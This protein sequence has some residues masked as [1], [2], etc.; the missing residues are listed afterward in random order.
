MTTRM[1]NQVLTKKKSQLMNLL[2]SDLV[3]AGS[4]A[5]PLEYQWEDEGPLANQVMFAAFVAH[6]PLE[7][8][9]KDFSPGLVRTSNQTGKNT[10]SSKP[11]KAPKSSSKSPRK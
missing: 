9:V 2:L 4:K 7:F 10:T 1:W 11:T 6:S 5:A 8:E 3:P